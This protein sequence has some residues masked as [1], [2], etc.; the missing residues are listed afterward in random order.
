[1]FGFIFVFIVGIA[2]PCQS[3]DKMSNPT[4]VRQEVQSSDDPTIKGL[5]WNRWT[6][7]NFTVCSINDKQAEFLNENLEKVK[8]WATN[9]WGL[10]D[11]AFAS[12]CRL[13]C[14]DDAALFKKLF[15]LTETKVEIRRENGKI[16]QTVIFL[17]LN[18]LPSKIIPLPLTEV[19]LAEFEQKNGIKLGTWAKRGI[20]RLN[21]SLPDIRRQLTSLHLFVNDDKGLYFGKSLFEMTDEQYLKESPENQRV[22]DHC[23][24]VVCLMLRKEFGQ[25]K[26]QTVSDAIEPRRSSQGSVYG[27][28]GYAQFDGSFK[29]Y[30]KDLS[31]D[32]AGVNGRS[33]P[34]H[35]LQ[36]LPK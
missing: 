23:S 35:Y 11:D 15:N 12:E 19:C 2:L 34:D 13:L 10:P 18:D 14:V 36:V 24:V 6:S 20:A 33:T 32:V 27:F 17:L 4:E 9:R 7:K 16:K 5:V 8:S 29:Q 31:N 1:M 30:M 28:A 26:F 21:C 25:D 22:F 3:L